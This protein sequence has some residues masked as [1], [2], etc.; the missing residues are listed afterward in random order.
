MG[1][2]TKLIPEKGLRGSEPV[3]GFY[4]MFESNRGLDLLSKESSRGAS[5][6]VGFPQL[7]SEIPVRPN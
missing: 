2:Q 7:T 4:Y 1:H 5:N 3:E 6:H